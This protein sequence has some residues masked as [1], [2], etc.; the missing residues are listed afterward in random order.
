MKRLVAASLLATVPATVAVA[1]D[2]LGPAPTGRGSLDGDGVSLGLAPIESPAGDDADPLGLGLVVEDAASVD[3]AGYPLRA[4]PVQLTPGRV[5]EL[6]TNDVLT[7]LPGAPSPDAVLAVAGADGVSRGAADGCASGKTFAWEPSCLTVTVPWDAAAAHT[8]YLRAARAWT[9]GQTTV[10]KRDV[11]YPWRPGPYEAITD[12]EV[13]FGGA[14]V[15]LDTSATDDAEAQTWHRPGPAERHAL[16]VLRPD[17]LAVAA[18]HVGD[19]HLGL[20]AGAA[21]PRGERVVIAYGPARADHAGP[22]GHVL[23]LPTVDPDTDQLLDWDGDGLSLYVEARLRSCD[24]PDQ[25]A[26]SDTFACAGPPG[27]GERDAFHAPTCRASLRDTDRDGLGDWVE[28][29]GATAA[30]LTGNEL[31][32]W[33]DATPRA[34]SLELQRMGADPAHRDLFVELDAF[35]QGPSSA[36][37]WEGFY[38]ST[39]RGIGGGA[40]FF[41]A[42]QAVFDHAP[43]WMNPDGTPGIRLHWDVGVANTSDPTSTVYNDWGG[44]NSMLWVGDGATCNREQAYENT[45]TCVEANGRP[46][47]APERRGLF[48]H[49]SDTPGTS[50]GQASSRLPTYTAAATEAHAHELG[51]LG[52]LDHEGPEG[53]AAQR[54]AFA[55]NRRANYP[56]IMNYA[57]EFSNGVTGDETIW[58]RVSFSA[59]DERVG[60]SS[61]LPERCALADA[62]AILITAADADPSTP[63]IDIDWNRDG[64]VA[65]EAPADRWLA[66]ERTARSTTLVPRAGLR[67]VPDLSIQGADTLLMATGQPGPDGADWLVLQ[68]D[69]DRDCARYPVGAPL[70]YPPCFAADVPPLVALGQDLRPIEIDAVAIAPITL[71]VGD[72]RSDTSIVVWSRHGRLRW[73]KL[74]AVRDRADAELAFDEHA[75]LDLVT[76]G[77]LRTFDVETYPGADLVHL[78]A[79]DATGAIVE[80]TYGEQE[81]YTTWLLRPA[82]GVVAVDAAA[83]ALGFSDEGLF[84]AVASATGDVRL[85]DHDHWSHQW[86]HVQTL[87]AAAQPGIRPEEGIA[88]AA[89]V[90]AYAGEP[91]SQQRLHLYY[92]VDD[93]RLQVRTSP[94]ATATGSWSAPTDLRGVPA[95]YG[96][97]A[98]LYD[99]RDLLDRGRRGLRLLTGDSAM[100][101]EDCPAGTVWTPYRGACIDVRTLRPHQEVRFYPFAD[102][103]D[104][105]VYAD[106][107]DWRGLQWGQCH[108]LALQGP[109]EDRCHCGPRPGYVEPTPDGVVPQ[110]DAWVDGCAPPAE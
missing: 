6:R 44:G 11:T 22:V 91:S 25:L 69:R 97:A 40:D 55:G 78:V 75:G 73:G 61:R 27:C 105:T 103:V 46:T 109:T 58:G 34:P 82:D 49:G 81:G 88:L 101:R 95:G 80:G 99:D 28:V 79:I 10:W 89:V 87:P 68:A 98:A 9:P 70:A 3:P 60:S 42:I 13:T 77:G 38:P 56:S 92:R 104:P 65:G 74:R 48:V 106:Y 18:A 7:A 66:Q 43:A 26:P 50:G 15:S 14:T 102:G 110:P 59:G 16:W 67:V 12:G 53:S 54:S 23:H 2:A 96:V 51:H 5:W 32:R 30:L 76:A 83:V 100:R 35:D 31:T 36:D 21:L 39:I 33:L 90:D 47:F 8:V 94:L 20:G 41:E 19:G 57:Y 107:D 72:G 37:T 52:R 64:V 63:C 29:H 71:D 24:R 108:T 86:R 85:Y 17:G 84:L 62:T 45:A 4:I 93:G 1:G